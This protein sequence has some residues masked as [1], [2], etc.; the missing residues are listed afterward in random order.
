VQT[1]VGELHLGLDTRRPRDPDAGRAA[2]EMVEQ[3]CL[4]SPRFASKNEHPALPRPHGR[5]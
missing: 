1:R 4:T 2:R 5:E 3:R